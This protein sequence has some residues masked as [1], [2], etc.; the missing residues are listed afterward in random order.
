MTEEVQLRDEEDVSSGVPES[1]PGRVNKF[2]PHGEHLVYAIYGIQSKKPE[3]AGKYAADLV[4]LL[5]AEGGAQ[6]V[7]RGAHKDRQGFYTE[8][9]MGYW[10]NKA[11]YY[12]FARQEEFSAWWGNL[13][14]DADSDVGFFKEVLLTQ[15]DY[16]HYAAGT[17]DR[18]ASAAVLELQG[19]DKFGYWG[20]YRDRLPA[21]IED[22]FLPAYEVM[23][24]PL[25]QETKG[26]RLSVNLPENIC[27]IREGQGFG[28]CDEREKQIWDKQMASRIDTWI[29]YLGKAPE[30]TGC[31]S[32]RDCIESDIQTNLPNLRQS[33]NAFLLSLSHIER[34]AR[35]V[36]QHLDVRSAFIDMFS[37]P[38]FTPAMHVWVEVH[39]LKQGDMEV[40]YVN[41][42]PETGFLRFFEAVTV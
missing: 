32:I 9:V 8:I 35:T 41:C 4:G 26:K 27:F 30:K 12:E 36:C 11:P 28:N 16:F 39:I 33:Q 23:P 6:Q 38:N 31:I 19:S 21:S 7:E 42:H 34:A 10:L 17:E 29:D 14:S 40:E 18:V 15:K 25:M 5:S 24:E 20:A 2:P 22:K 3:L 13:P 37:D 1:Y